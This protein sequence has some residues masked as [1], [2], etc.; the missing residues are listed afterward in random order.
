MFRANESTSKK[1]TKQTCVHEQKKKKKKKKKKGLRERD[2]LG[3][4]GKAHLCH[5]TLHITSK[6]KQKRKRGKIN[7]IIII[8]IIIII[9]TGCLDPVRSNA[10][11]QRPRREEELRKGQP[12]SVEFWLRGWSHG[13]WK[14]LGWLDSASAAAAALAAAVAALVAVVVVA[15]VVAAAAAAAYLCQ[16]DAGGPED[17]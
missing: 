17:R 10:R 16:G 6:S 1:K 9:K 13:G 15:V 8:I 4:E 3:E 2:E 12:R 14:N 7:C 11:T 5:H